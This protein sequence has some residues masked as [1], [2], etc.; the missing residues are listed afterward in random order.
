MRLCR[1]ASTS[2]PYEAQRTELAQMIVH[3]S[4]SSRRPEFKFGWTASP[5]NSGVDVTTAEL[6]LAVMEELLAG[7]PHPVT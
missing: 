6:P 2:M 3:C 7:T 1:K 4:P 5:K